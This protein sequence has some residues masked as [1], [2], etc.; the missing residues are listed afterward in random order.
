MLTPKE[1]IHFRAAWGCKR[2]ELGKP[3][4]QAL[5]K[6]RTDWGRGGLTLKQGGRDF[7]RLGESCH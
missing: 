2:R 6:W 1:K 3:F 5:K 7:F 4:V